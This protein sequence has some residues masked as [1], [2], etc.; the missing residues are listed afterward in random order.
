MA[1]AQSIG[2]AS[3]IEA[4]AAAPEADAT[5]ALYETYARQIYGYCLHKLGSKEE[6][7]DAVQTTFR[8]AFRG[9]RRG[10]VP[11]SEQ[12]WLFKI[13]ENVC[14]SRH[15]SSWRRGKVEQTTDLQALQDLIPALERA[16]GEDLL[17]LQDALA[18]M[19]ANQRHAILLREWQGLSYSE[20][21]ERMKLSQSAVETLIFRARRALASGL[22]ED[23]EPVEGRR[24]LR[25]GLDLGS[26]F[27]GLKSLLT[28][29]AAVKAAAVAVAVTA[30]SVAA[31][32]SLVHKR[33]QHRPRAAARILTH[34]AAATPIVAAPIANV[35]ASA[36]VRMAASVP[37]RV[38]RPVPARH[39]TRRAPAAGRTAPIP[40][41]VVTS[42]PAEQV[43]EPAVAPPVEIAP[44][45]APVADPPHLVE[46]PKYEQPIGHHQ[47][48]LPAPEPPKSEHEHGGGTKAGHGH[49][50]KPTDVGEPPAAASA[51]H[52]E[53]KQ[54]K[55][56]PAEAAPAP[57]EAAP[58]DPSASAQG[59][60]SGHG[61]DHGNGG[62]GDGGQGD[63][64]GKSH[65]GKG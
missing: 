53:P 31:T 12:A 34:V 45:G 60:D 15:R 39:V 62:G 32:D 33:V 22:A 35:A 47:P 63:E 41:A 37:P 42:G 64:G 58:V 19:P 5:R 14:L 30:T 3:S 11:E 1:A 10:V 13:A 55:G 16:G 9:L 20:I 43:Q 23:G 17:R 40:I 4:P 2:R 29:G 44:A 49:D 56:A 28:G 57:E 48:K 38:V 8:N 54:D 18:G 46:Q 36:P 51:K 65:T 59:T 52:E 27:A 24:R 25:K 21:A 7:E 50:T 26:V 6:A 61:G